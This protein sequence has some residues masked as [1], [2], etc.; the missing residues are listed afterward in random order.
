VRRKRPFFLDN[1]IIETRGVVYITTLLTPMRDYERGVLAVAVCTGSV[2][3]TATDTSHDQ[4]DNAE[5]EAREVT[6]IGRSLT[7]FEQ[8]S[9][10][11]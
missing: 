9:V 7:N 11:R 2:A 1:R 5:N 6:R 8:V 3:P 10:L 4:R